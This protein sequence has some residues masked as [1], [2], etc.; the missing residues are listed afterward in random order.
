[1]LEKV[2]EVREVRDIVEKVKEVR[3]VLSGSE[4]KRMRACQQYIT[5]AGS[6]VA[7]ARIVQHVLELY[8]TC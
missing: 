8:S 1:M 4:G 3:G 6:M 5:G 2:R 7:R